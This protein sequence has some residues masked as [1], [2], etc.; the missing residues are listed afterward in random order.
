MHLSIVHKEGLKIK[1]EPKSLE[2]YP[3]QGTETEVYRCE[4]CKSNFETKMI[5]DQHNTF[6]HKNDKVFK[7]EI[8]DY[9]FSQKGSLKSH[10]ASIHE[11]KKPFKCKMCD[12][13]SPKKVI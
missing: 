12:Y 6:Y 8:S 10:V 9:N 7:C 2:N 3:I 11:G 13:N 1:V 4:P 5:L